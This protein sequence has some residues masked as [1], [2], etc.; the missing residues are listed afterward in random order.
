TAGPVGDQVST[1]PIGCYQPITLLLDIAFLQDGEGGQIVQCAN[2]ARDQA[3]LR[4]TV[5]IKG[6]LTVGMIE[7][8]A[9][10]V[11]LKLAELLG[12]QKLSPLV[13]PKVS[14]LVAVSRA[15]QGERMK[16]MANERLI[17]PHETYCLPMEPCGGKFP[18][19]PAN[20][21]SWKLA[22]TLPARCVG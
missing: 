11:P 10:A 13:F 20:R 17:D 15:P 21:A 1:G 2:I 16:Q 12:R 4:K 22:P 7:Q 3:G 8:R 14:K 18:T 6:A 5:P 19:C 9:Q